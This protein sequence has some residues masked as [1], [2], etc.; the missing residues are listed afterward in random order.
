MA[1]E[2][3]SL[4]SHSASSRLSFYSGHSSF[5]MYCMMFLVVSGPLAK[6]AR[7]VSLPL[8]HYSK[9]LPPKENAESWPWLATDLSSVPLLSCPWFQLYIQARLVGRWAR[10]VRPTVQFFL[11]SFAI[12]VGY[13]RVSDYKHHW[14]DVVVGLLQ[15]AL[16]AVLMVRVGQARRQTW[17]RGRRP[18][19]GDPL[20]SYI[21]L[22]SGRFDLNPSLVRSSQGRGHWGKRHFSLCPISSSF[23]SFLQPASEIPRLHLVFPECLSHPQFARAEQGFRDRMSWKDTHKP[24]WELGCL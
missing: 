23:S 19:S 21:Q 16:I 11:L 22:V 6:I 9:E 12:Y 8:S 2:Q 15:G 13:T 7:H 14:S 24:I 4:F 10:L 3:T 5:G 1:R 20:I 17:G 18:E